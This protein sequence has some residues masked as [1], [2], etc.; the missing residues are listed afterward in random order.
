[1]ITAKRIRAAAAVVIAC[2]LLLE[3][4]MRLLL[5][6]DLFGFSGSTIRDPVVG[7][8]PKPGIVV[9]EPFA[10]L[11]TIGE[12]SVRLNRNPAVPERPMIVAVGDSFTF[13]QDVGDSDSWPAALER[14]L[15]SRVVNGGVNAFG[16]DQTVLRGERLSEIFA[17][18]LLIVGF[19]PHNV[20][21]CEFSFF[22]GHPKPYFELDGD[23]LREHPPPVPGSWFA[24]IRDR[25]L[26]ISMAAYLFEHSLVWEGPAEERVHGD[27]LEVA[28]RLMQRLA[29]L[30]RTRGMRV[31]VLAQ[32]QDA[33]LE[34]GDAT[35]KDRVL[36]CARAGGL[37]TVDLF[38]LL[39]DVP[40]PEREKLFKGHMTPAGNAFV[41]NALATYLRK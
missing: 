16:L 39:A 8:L 12:H 24:P 32:S 23:G 3:G 14:L 19:I 25:L 38:P 5:L 17:P 2:G 9:H 27:G 36:A 4:L 1:M 37:A 22:L 20:M 18:E 29:D 40:V 30:G 28:C 7:R 21:R 6:H 11:F 34:A 33:A 10:G 26:S 31:V 13:G 41:A 15:G 35:I